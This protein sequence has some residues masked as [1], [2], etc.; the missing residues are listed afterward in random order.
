M[1]PEHLNLAAKSFTPPPPN[2]AHIYV[3]RNESIGAA[4]KMEL[5]LNGFP[6]GKTVAKT[7]T[8]LPVLPGQ[9]MLTSEAEN[10]SMLPIQAMPG[11][12]VFVW[13]EVKMGFLYARTALQRVSPAVGRAGVLECNLILSPALP[14]PPPPQVPPTPLPA[15]AV[16]VPTPPQS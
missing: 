12:V 10:T 8:L 3:Y 14:P 1:A 7:F 5:K 9:H 4:V 16:N 11:E 2:L 6:A 13:Q 15:P